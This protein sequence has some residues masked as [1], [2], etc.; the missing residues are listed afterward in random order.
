MAVISDLQR[1]TLAVLRLK[2]S[3][4]KFLSGYPVTEGQ[5]AICSDARHDRSLYL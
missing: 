4:I 5:I 3:R 2:L 1:D